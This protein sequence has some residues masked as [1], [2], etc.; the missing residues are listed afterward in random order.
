[1]EDLAVYAVAAM[2][3]MTPGLLLLRVAGSV[4]L[5]LLSR[6]QESKEEFERRYSFCA[7]TLCLVS[8]CV[9]VFLVVLG[10]PLIVRI[11]G[12]KYVAACTLIGWLGVMQALRMIR[13]VPTVAA[14]AKGDT[15]NLMISNMARSTGLGLALIAASLRLPLYTMAICGI[16]GEVVSLTVSVSRLWLRHR[17]PIQVVIRPALVAVGLMGLAGYA[18]R[19]SVADP[20]GISDAIL[21]T[22]GLCVTALALTMGLF[23]QFRTGVWGYLAGGISASSGLGKGA[24]VEGPTKD[25][26]QPGTGVIQ[27]PDHAGGK[28]QG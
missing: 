7:Q 26:A 23:S 11:Y 13:A 2:L 9:A 21:W 3:A 24:E 5:P 16:I 18:Y 15:K 4:I 8:G 19:R 20:Y 27:T 17:L 1:M 22:L 6:V 10:P 12:D 25:E 14:M 28:P